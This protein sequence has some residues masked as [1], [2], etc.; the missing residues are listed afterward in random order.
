MTDATRKQRER[1]RRKDAGEVRLEFWVPADTADA[2]RE[3][4]ADV[5]REASDKPHPA[6][7]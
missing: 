7:L 6:A 1:Q 4:V 3:A 2:V 5:L